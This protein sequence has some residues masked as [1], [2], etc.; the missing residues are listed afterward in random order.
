MMCSGVL[1]S[2]FGQK[3]CRLHSMRVSLIT[4]AALPAA[5]MKVLYSLLN[6]S[7]ARA[8]TTMPS[9]LHVQYIAV[10]LAAAVLCLLLPSSNSA[11]GIDC[12]CSSSVLEY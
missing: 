2:C 8:T 1:S 7:S 5:H 9:V 6:S 11:S 3:T 4:A 10:Q 12:A